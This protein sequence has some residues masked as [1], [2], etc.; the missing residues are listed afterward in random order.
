MAA[1]GASVY[2][3]GIVPS[4]ADSEATSKPVC[5]L[6]AEEK[7]VW[8]PNPNPYSAF[9]VEYRAGATFRIAASS[10]KYPQGY[11]EAVETV[12]SANAVE[13]YINERVAVYVVFASWL[14][15]TCF[16]L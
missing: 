10:F 1:N 8:T 15:A 2:G 7:S 4:I 12:A 13:D 14:F 6:P 5:K 11:M 16:F 3:P 9:R